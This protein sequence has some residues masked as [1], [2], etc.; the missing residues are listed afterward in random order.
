[1]TIADELRQAVAA[2]ADEM[3]TS[4]NY[5]RLC[6]AVLLIADRLDGEGQVAAFPGWSLR[7][8]EPSRS[9]R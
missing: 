8:D 1:M 4:A 5:D 6:D 7:V 2:A 3:F 9:V